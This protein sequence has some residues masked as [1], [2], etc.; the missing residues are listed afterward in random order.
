[1]TRSIRSFDI[2]RT[3]IVVQSAAALACLLSV[4]GCAMGMG[5]AAEDTSNSQSNSKKFV[6]NGG[7]GGS[8]GSTGTAGAGGSFVR[9]DDGGA[10]HG[11]NN[12][13]GSAG[14][15]GFG[16]SAGSGHFACEDTDGHNCSGDMGYG[17]H[18]DPSENTNGCSP[19]KFWAWCNRRN[20]KYPD[21][22]DTYLQ[23]WVRARCDGEVTLEDPNNDGYPTYTCHDSK[24]GTWECTTPLVL[25]FDGTAV[26]YAPSTHHFA[27]QSGRS[28]GSATDWPTA[29]TP[30]LAMDRDGNGTIDSG[31]E[32]FGSSTRLAGGEPAR[33]GF[34][35]LA[36]LDDNVDGVIDSKDS[37][38]CRLMAWSDRN[39]DG[40][41][42]KDELV[43]VRDLGLVAI[44]LASTVQSRCDE[45]GNCEGE[46]STFFWN[47]G[48]TLTRGAVID[49]YLRLASSR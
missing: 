19:E 16:G 40:V 31:A 24:G 45:N 27:L 48:A 18:C 3:C 8:A 29:T 23:A 14:S 38:W 32:L 5:D 35:A 42:Q 12:A 7:S 39:A 44:G 17:D 1:M 26:Q 13:G 2:R 34:E 20:D 36:E 21:I 46:R 10:G 9:T 6:G 49:V 11:A 15:D 4:S 30:W 43:L 25:S 33:N 47:S 22:W 37:A 28:D 41:S